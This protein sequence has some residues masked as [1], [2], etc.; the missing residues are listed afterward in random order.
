MQYTPMSPS[1]PPASCLLKR[2]FGGRVFCTLLASIWT[3]RPNVLSRH[4]WIAA[5]LYGS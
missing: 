4:I 1:G 5:W 3:I 2:M